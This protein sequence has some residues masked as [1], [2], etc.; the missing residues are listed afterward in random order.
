MFPVK[1]NK[2]SIQSPDLSVSKANQEK[3]YRLIENFL[4][5]TQ[6]QVQENIKNY[7]TLSTIMRFIKKDKSDPSE[8]QVLEVVKRMERDKL[9]YQIALQISEIT[10]KQ[11]EN[12]QKAMFFKMI[13]Y[14][15]GLLGVIIISSLILSTKPLSFE[16]PVLIRNLILLL[17]F[18]GI[19]IWGLLKRK[20]AKVEMLASNI[21]LQAASAYASAKMQGKSHIAAMQNLAEMKRRAKSE[22][23]KAKEKNKK[24]KEKKK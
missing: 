1:K 20:L 24:S 11:A 22:D 2:M 5:G 10:G 17:I 15:I 23:L 13:P 19:F 3:A 7:S 21:L 8:K 18:T 14:F 6:R 4:N 16:N 9:H 12:W